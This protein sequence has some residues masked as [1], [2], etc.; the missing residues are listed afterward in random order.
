MTVSTFVLHDGEDDDKT[1]ELHAFLEK[2]KLGKRGEWEGY[3]D[4]IIIY[5]QAEAGDTI[6][7]DDETGAVRVIEAT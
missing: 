1:A 4:G 6:E 3:G 5:L 2:A 7:I